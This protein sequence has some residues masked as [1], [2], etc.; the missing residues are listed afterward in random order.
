MT[1]DEQIAKFLSSPAFA[2]AGASVKR[3]KYGNMV[4]RCYQQQGKK[5]IPVHPLEKE[6]EGIACVSSVAALDPEVKS[7]SIITPPQVTE[8][9]V[10]T[11]IAHGIENI[12]MQPGAESPAVVDLCRAAGVNVIADGS[13][14]L[15]V[16][17][18]RGH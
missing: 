6:I 12:W 16:L 17:G 10:A 7:L 11:A 5:V 8:K 15:V 1:I 18:F 13:C 2:V 4:V 9:I 3:E 14:L